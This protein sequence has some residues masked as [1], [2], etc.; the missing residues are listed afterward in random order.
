MSAFFANLGTITNA[1]K[2]QLI[3]AINAALGLLIAFNVT[4]TQAQLGAIDVAANAVL[5]LIVAITFTQ[6]SKRTTTAAK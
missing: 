6:S 2:A 3:A 1:T 4:L 5:A